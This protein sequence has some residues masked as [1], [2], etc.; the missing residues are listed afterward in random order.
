M[1]DWEKVK[2]SVW[3]FPKKKEIVS[4]K[5]NTSLLSSIFDEVSVI[6]ILLYINIVLFF[7]VVMTL[8]TI[9]KFCLGVDCDQLKICFLISEYGIR[10][11][12]IK[13][14]NI[15]IILSFPNWQNDLSG[16]EK[17]MFE[18]QHDRVIEIQVNALRANNNIIP[19]KWHNEKHMK[20]SNHNLKNYGI[21][22][23]QNSEK[24]IW[25]FVLRQIESIHIPNFFVNNKISNI[26]LI[27]NY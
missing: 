22:S 18:L 26:I 7:N 25:F 16:Q 5:K 23:T 11:F 4:K 20:I 14:E 3:I 9:G 19:T 12:L 27:I 17:K 6:N 24:K 2:R 21:V 13:F 1:T 10:W 8:V 15:I